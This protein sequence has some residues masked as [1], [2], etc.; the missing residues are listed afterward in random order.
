M[1]LYLS[2][3]VDDQRRTWA[4]DQPL[5]GIGR[6]SRNTIHLPDP[7]VS[8][9]HAQITLTDGKIELRDLGSRN[10]VRVNGL[11]IES[12]VSL[13]A[14]DRVEI[15]AFGLQVS[16]GEPT[17]TIRLVDATVMDTSVKLRADQLIERR[18]AGSGSGAR[19]PIIQWL[20]QAGQM[21][22]IPR[23]LHETCDELLE[24]VARA[25]PASRYVLLLQEK[26]DA[27]PI[28][29]ASRVAGG[30]PDRPL[31]LSRT[32][33]HHVITTC[34]AVVTREPSQ[35]PRF[36]GH[37]S[38]ISSA[39][40]SA[41]AVPLFDNQKV[42][43]VLYV[44]TLDPRVVFDESQ[45]EVLTLLGNMA[46]VKITNARLLEHEQVRARMAQELASATRIQRGLLPTVLPAVAGW[47][48]DA[49]LETCFEVGGD[50]YD[51][52]V[53]PDGQVM[54]AIGDVSGKGMGAALLMSSF[55]SSL[56]VLDDAGMEP[57]SLANRLGSV[58]ARNTD[59]GMFVTGT[60]GCLDP[61]TG[62]AKVVN[63]G[64]LPTYV[65]RDG[66][67]EIYESTGIPF[68]IL[69]AFTYTEQ[70]IAL[71]PGETL[72][73]F[74]DGIPEAQRGD[75]FFDEDRLKQVLLDCAKSPHCSEMREAVMQSVEAFLKG[76]HRTDDIT[77]VMLRRSATV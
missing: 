23:P 60:L 56:R 15:G 55:V 62:V 9:E 5:I 46:A 36:V 73:L 71:A 75:E 58:T 12:T 65:V 19:A 10:G 59:S 6:S 51:V 76:A 31:V 30:R 32:I 38:V 28:P 27:E 39:A 13:T 2:G 54:F 33:L 52:R 50:L 7:S 22:V 11:R 63:A 8:R 67:V 68:G 35:D 48:L 72:V 29:I 14:G 44:D 61:E 47:Q 70:E 24:V 69:P 20:A 45:L 17:S 40:R 41:M 77:V 3:T 26:P 42:L 66:G 64:H 16:E 18:A 53:R 21:L 25:V 57:A 1:T 37:Q 49:H 34:A 43:G 4:L 74:T